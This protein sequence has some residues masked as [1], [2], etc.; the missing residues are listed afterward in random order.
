MM[1][2]SMKFL[3]RSF[4]LGGILFLN[5]NCVL[6][7][8]LSQTD[9]KQIS[10]EKRAL[11]SELL[12]VSEAKKNALAIFNA[13]LDE[14]QRQMPD[15]VWQGLLSQTE[16]QELDAEA[17]DALR[18]E[19]LAESER[20]NKRVRELFLAGINMA[21]VIEDVSVDLYDKYFTDDEIKDL[22][23]FYK[24]HTGK[25]T[26]EVLPKMFAESMTNTMDAVKP[27]V[28]EIV[29]QLVNEETAR[30]KKELETKK[31][32]AARTR[33]PQSRTRRKP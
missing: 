18:K 33:P 5:F 17:R 20:M 15:I 21:L 16:V 6:S 7:Q 14:N 24:S 9:A 23:V 26:T 22:I 1:P 32:P 19:L 13:M 12:E 29:A 30:V 3:A 27:K 2:M 31:T 28:L 11:I 25:K 8:Q 10:P 4:I